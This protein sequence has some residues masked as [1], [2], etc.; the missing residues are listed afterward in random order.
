MIVLSG[1]DVVLPD[2]VL[3]PGALV[4]DGERI[5]RAEIT[6]EVVCDG[7]LVHLQTS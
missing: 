6:A 3:S 4:L 2:R 5:V 7:V 1:A